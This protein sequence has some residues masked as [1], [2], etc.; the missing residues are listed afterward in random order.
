MLGPLLIVSL[1][2][3]QLPAIE[4]SALAEACADGGTEASRACV[5]TIIAR[6]RDA[7]ECVGV[8]E[9]LRAWP[10]AAA[11]GCPESSGGKK[12]GWRHPKLRRDPTMWDLRNPFLRAN[13]GSSRPQPEQEAAAAASD[14]AISSSTAGKNDD[15][16]RRA[17]HREA[18]KIRLARA[19]LARARALGLRNPFGDHTRR[20]PDESALGLR[21]PFR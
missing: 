4:P 7:G 1:L 17:G 20:R 6:R 16:K 2:R 15:S 21:D 10:G 9:G 5:G 11:T 3:P 19:D 12:A 8:S 18:A 13:P 14:T